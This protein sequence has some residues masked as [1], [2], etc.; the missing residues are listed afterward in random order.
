M[1]RQ[2]GP[3]SF[4]TAPNGEDEASTICDPVELRLSSVTNAQGLCFVARTDEEGNCD[5]CFYSFRGQLRAGVYIV[6]V[7]TSS[8]GVQ[9][10]N[11]KQIVASSSR[12][13]GSNG[14]SALRYV[15]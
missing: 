6:P 9:C 7:S 15:K 2:L 11:G 14:D 13:V 8:C 1:F 12:A 3:R 5:T 10:A 4:A